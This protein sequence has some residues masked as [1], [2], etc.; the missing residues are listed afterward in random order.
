VPDF[1]VPLSDEVAAQAFLDASAADLP[2]PPKGQ[3]FRARDAPVGKVLL[4]TLK[5]EA[6]GIYKA[7]AAHFAGRSRLLFAW[8]RASVA[9]GPGVRLMQKMNV[10]TCVRACVRACAR[11]WCVAC[12]AL[13]AA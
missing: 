3:R 2:V 8:A 7:L 5:D 10:R 4:F 1:T 6:P 11:V 13:G 12:T 9:D